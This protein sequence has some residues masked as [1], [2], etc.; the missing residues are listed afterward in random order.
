MIN[1]SIS[2]P[3]GRLGD[4]AHVCRGATI[5]V[6]S[7]Y[8]IRASETEVYCAAASDDF[9]CC[10]I[11]IKAHVITWVKHPFTNPPKEIIPT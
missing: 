11:R 7:I 10:L 8:C 9:C 2:L 1:I 4:F 5:D 6:L 3:S